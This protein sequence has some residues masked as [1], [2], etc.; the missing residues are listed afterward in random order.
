MGNVFSKEFFTNQN[1]P[2]FLK[3]LIIFVLQFFTGTK[4]TEYETYSHRWYNYF[5]LPSIYSS[6]WPGAKKSCPEK[7]I[8]LFAWRK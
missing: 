2:V 6:Y 7:Q 3:Y 4:Q 5:N 8:K 1:M